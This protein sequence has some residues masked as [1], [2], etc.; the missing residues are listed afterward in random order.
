MEEYL[1]L[2]ALGMIYPIVPAIVGK[3]ILFEMMNMSNIK[4]SKEELEVVEKD[5]EKRIKPVERMMYVN[6]VIFF[7]NKLHNTSKN[8]PDSLDFSFRQLIN[9]LQERLEN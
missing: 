1:K 6:E 7:I 4:L 2:L 5:F 8:N 9:Q 3:K